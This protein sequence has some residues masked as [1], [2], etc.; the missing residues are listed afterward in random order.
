MKEFTALHNRIKM[1]DAKY[2]GSKK[3]HSEKI[4]FGI[5]TA[6]AQLERYAQERYYSGY[7]SL[8]DLTKL[9]PSHEKI[10]NYILPG[11][12]DMGKSITNE[13]DKIPDYIEKELFDIF[14]NEAIYRNQN[15]IRLMFLHEELRLRTL[16][17]ETRDFYKSNS[18]NIKKAML[19]INTNERLMKEAKSEYESVYNDFIKKKKHIEE[20][21]SSHVR[22]LLETCSID[23]YEVQNILLTLIENIK[24]AVTDRKVTVNQLD[25]LCYDIIGLIKNKYPF[26][27]K[28][29]ISV[30]KGVTVVVQMH[31]DDFNRCIKHIRALIDYKKNL[32]IANQELEATY[33]FGDIHMI[34]LLDCI[35]NTVHRNAPRY[36]SPPVQK[37]NTKA[38]VSDGF[39]AKI[40]QV[41]PDRF[42]LVEKLLFDI[43]D[44]IDEHCKSES[45][46]RFGLRLHKQDNK[47]I[48]EMAKYLRNLN[49]HPFT[50]L[51]VMYPVINWLNCQ[52]NT[53][54]LLSIMDIIKPLFSH[55][56]LAD[57]HTNRFKSYIFNVFEFTEQ[58]K[59]IINEFMQTEFIALSTDSTSN[60]MKYHDFNEK[61]KRIIDLPTPRD[62]K[63]SLSKTM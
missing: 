31:F 23:N 50:K 10:I 19:T 32:Q 62:D 14:S 15:D 12:K 29:S 39:F 21:I 53:K 51:C 60:P 5:S 55:V 20:E 33:K 3:I 59:S 58:Q 11:L 22:K 24:K 61:I 18:E 27:K 4:S 36:T 47:K 63:S 57:T 28:L 43:A 56:N 7:E 6:L 54:L 37:E 52:Q 46:S 30:R 34:S 42:V 45:K 48:K 8:I 16:N 9:I 38:K 25:E 35:R 41:D 2:L 26:D 17:K 40:K 13:F 44:K 49:Y 1:L